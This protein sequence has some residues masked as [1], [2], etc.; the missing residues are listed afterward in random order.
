MT[1]FFRFGDREKRWLYG[2]ALQPMLDSADA[3]AAI[4]SPF[5]AL[6]KEPVLRRMLFTD[7]VTKLPEHTL[8]LTD[9]LS[10]AHGLET[11]APLLDHT[12]AEFCATMPPDLHVRGGTTK[13]AL[14]RAAEGLLPTD[15][16]RRPKQGFMFPVAYWLNAGTL[17]D[18][19][20]RLLTGPAVSEGWI[21]P[22]AVERLCQEHL[23][24]RADH[25]VRIWMLLNLDAWLRLY[26]H[27]DAAERAIAV[28]GSS[29]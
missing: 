7:I 3:E 17:G 29:A 25:N 23:A 10:M 21:R 4:L 9:R 18:V 27:H 5:D 13:Y 2:P 20:A 26:L 28:A 12:L 6:R 1:T 11:R 8:M 22:D 19:R 15:I 16:L 24:R 14:R